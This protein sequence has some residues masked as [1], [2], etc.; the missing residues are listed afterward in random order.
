MRPLL[1]LSL[2]ALPLAALAQSSRDGAQ[3]RFEDARALAAE[4]DAAGALAVLDALADAGWASAEAEA[5]YAEIAAASGRPGSA[6]LAAARAR[7]LDPRVALDADLAPPPAAGPVVVA[8]RAR[9]LVGPVGLVALALALYLAAVAVGLVVWRDRRALPLAGAGAVGVLALVA[10]SVAGVALWDASQ[11]VGVVQ[12]E[13]EARAAPS[14]EAEVEGGLPPGTL[15]RLGDAAGGWR[16]VTVG[17]E[18]VWVPA[19]SVAPL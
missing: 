15:V 6:A 8:R 7:R 10:I 12:A 19:R 9:A 4:G 16:A 5:A 2:L 3:A 14:P 1:L 18:L 17:E 13:V 11:P